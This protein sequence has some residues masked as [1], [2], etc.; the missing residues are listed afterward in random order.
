ML[1]RAFATVSTLCSALL[2]GGC[3]LSGLLPDWMSTDVAGPEPAYRFVIANRLRDIIGSPAPPEKLEIS[4]AKRIDSLKGASWRV[5][6]KAQQFPL[7]PRY[8]ALFFQRGYMIDSRLS[9]LIDQCEIQSYSV[10]DWQHDINN[11]PPR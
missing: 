8:Y 7:L 10:F 3:A 9:V 4:E 1:L 6:L 2:L 5:C 11:P